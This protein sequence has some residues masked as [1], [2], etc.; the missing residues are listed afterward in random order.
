[1]VTELKILDIQGECEWGVCF[2]QPFPFRQ[3]MHDVPMQRF[4]FNKYLTG[5]F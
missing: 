2:L 5:G 3:H 1:M 4:Y